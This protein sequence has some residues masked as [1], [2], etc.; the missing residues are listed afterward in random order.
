MCKKSEMGED[1]IGSKTARLHTGKLS[2]WQIKLY[3]EDF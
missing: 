3:R 2:N 1:D